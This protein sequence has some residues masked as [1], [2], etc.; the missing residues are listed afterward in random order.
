MFSSAPWT[1]RIKAIVL[2]L[3]LGLALHTS[4]NWW[5]IFADHV[6]KC[7]HPN[8][9]ADFVTFYAEATIMRENRASLYDLDE[10]LRQQQKIAPTERVLPF[11]YPPITAL[12]FA[13][14]AWLPFSGAFLVMTVVNALLLWRSLKLLIQHLNMTRDQS[15]WLLLFALCN[16]GVHAVMFYGQTSLVILLVI[17]YF[18]TRHVLSQK[19]LEQYRAGFWAG[20]LYVKPQFLPIPHLVLLL[21][22]KWRGMLVGALVAFICIVGAFLVIGLEASRQYFRLMQRLITADNAWYNQLQVMHNFRALTVFWLPPTWKIFTWWGGSALLIGTIVWVNLRAT[23][24]SDGFEIRWIA[25]ILALLLVT[26]HLFAH[27]LTLLIVPCALFLSKFKDM[28]PVP[29]GIGLVAL[30]LL[31]IANPL[32]PTIMAIVLMILFAISVRFSVVKLSR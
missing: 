30:A 31:P 3:G 5:N 17:L 18:L 14:L 8:C 12:L 29:A 9:V 13:P 16:F 23:K 19:R 15:H 11:V 4:T 32:L 25:N 20:L 28:V 6:P 10:Q 24:N 22:G 7:G 27:D 1:N 2:G 21:R 26:P